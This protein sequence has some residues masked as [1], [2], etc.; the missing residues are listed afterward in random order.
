MEAILTFL[1]T[2]WPLI[3]AIVPALL[4]IAMAVAKVTPNETDNKV[5][6]FLQRAWDFLANLLG[7]TGRF[8][9]TRT[10]EAPPARPTLTEGT[11]D[12]AIVERTKLEQPVN[13]A[14][15]RAK[16]PR[17]FQIGASAPT[18]NLNHRAG[19]PDTDPQ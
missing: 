16:L 2:Y 7:A 6:A 4:L 15:V 10:S 9:S 12:R 14:P 18:T 17:E 5:V 3:A 13:D 1:T 11:E 19:E 8:G